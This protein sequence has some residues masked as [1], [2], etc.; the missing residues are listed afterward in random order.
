MSLSQ[1]DSFFFLLCVK[2][3]CIFFFSVAQFLKASHHKNVGSSQ[4]KRVKCLAQPKS[5]PNEKYLS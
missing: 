4:G 3:P 5:K 1:H 2:E